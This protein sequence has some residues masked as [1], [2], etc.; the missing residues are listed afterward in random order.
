VG[1]TGV[2]PATSTM[3]TCEHRDAS[4]NGQDVTA[5]PAPVCTRV[6]TSDADLEQMAD[7]LRSRLTAD[8]RVRLAKL[9]LD[10][11]Q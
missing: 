8:E 3:S 4:G 9:L 5:T 2:E 6:C 11:V 10:Q 7:D 1:G